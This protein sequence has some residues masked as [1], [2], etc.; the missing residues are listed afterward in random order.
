ML[1]ISILGSG[2]FGCAIASVYNKFNFNITLWS[3]SAEEAQEI[4]INRENKRCL[5]GINIDSKINITS[6]ISDVFDSDIIFIV[7]PSFAVRVTLNLIKNKIKPEAILVC[8]SKGFEESTLELLSDIIKE[9]LPQNKF[10]IL[11]GPSHAEEIAKEM[12]TTLV[13]AS[14]N[15]D[16]AIYIQKI[17][18]TSFI[19]IYT[20]TDIVGVQIGAA[21]KNIIALAIGICDGM[22]L[23]DNAKAALM[24]R[25]LSEISRLG[26]AA[27]A[28][29]KTFS[30]L[31][32]LG[33][34]IVTCTSLHSR[35]R[36]A[37]I[38]IGR[39]QNTDSAISKI[40][41]T[42]EGYSATKCAYNLSQKYNIELPIINEIYNILYKNKDPKKAFE[43]LF[44]R[45]Y[46]FE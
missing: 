40:G 44:S 38:L 34:L 33:D 23:G 46:K 42:V 3:H 30:G 6:N 8:L 25:G 45:P 10:V 24:T 5:P 9:I 36:R 12:T 22:N 16:T 39:G 41:M 31:S 17:F 18:S 29:Q 37:G 32:G 14:E 13:A 35:N 43:N 27:G 19:R 11:S 28:N 7:V 20:N 26:V 15:I 4:K 2:S 1:T 21:L